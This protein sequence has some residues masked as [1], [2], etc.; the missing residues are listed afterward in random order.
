MGIRRE[1]HMGRSVVGSVHSRAAVVLGVKGAPHS[2]LG[3]FVVAHLVPRL[4]QFATP[5]VATPIYVVDA[6][7]RAVR[8][9]FPV[10]HPLREREVDLVTRGWSIECDL[11]E[12]NSV[13]GGTLSTAGVYSL[14]GT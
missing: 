1:T 14:A 2:T 13:K 12:C 6:A 8:C 3:R 10:R 5:S 9:P 7:P 11:K 4:L